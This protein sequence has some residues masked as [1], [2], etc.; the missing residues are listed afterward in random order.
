MPTVF[1]ILSGQH[2]QASFDNIRMI[3]ET[4]GMDIQARPTLP[5]HELLQK[6]AEEKARQLV[7]LVQ[8]TSALE[9]QAVGDEAVNEMTRRTV[10][11]LLAGSPRKLWG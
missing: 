5:A 8:G 4:L 9:S 3:A 2:K 1:R 10:H 6:T 7:G 11:E